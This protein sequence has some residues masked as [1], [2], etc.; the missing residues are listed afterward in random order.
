VETYHKWYRDLVVDANDSRGRNQ[1][2]EFK[3][4]NDGVGM[5]RGVE[6]FLKQNVGEKFFGWLSYAYSRSWRRNFGG[7]NWELYEY[8]QPHVATL[9][10]SYAFT[11][12]WR[13]GTKVRYSSGSLITPVVRAYKDVHGDWNPV[14]GEPNSERLGDYVRVDLRVEHGFLYSGWKLNLYFEVLNLFDRGNPS[15]YEYNDD[16]SEKKTVNSLPRLF[17]LGL[18]AHF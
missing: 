16:Y 11:P 7:D 4:S 8:D 14:Y 15:G 10:T 6:V 5:A 12:V 1:A 2:G 17:Y 13:L 9:V 3:L 18:G